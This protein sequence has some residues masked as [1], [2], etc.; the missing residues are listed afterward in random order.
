MKEILLVTD[1]SNDGVGGFHGRLTPPLGEW[2]LRGKV[3]GKVDAPT[4]VCNPGGRD[5]W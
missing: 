4:G 2:K 5:Q 1:V 3:D